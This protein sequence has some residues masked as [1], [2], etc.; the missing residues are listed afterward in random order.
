MPDSAILNARRV[1]L[2]GFFRLHPDD[3]ARVMETFPVTEVVSLLEGAVPASGAAIFGRLSP[4]VAAEVL[5]RASDDLAG[6]FIGALSPDRAA[7]LLSRVEEKERSR[8]LARLNHAAA[9]E[10][11]T[12]MTY[13]EETAGRLM[14]PH[15]V[16]FRR[17]TIVRQVLS[18]LRTLRE[19]RVHE[20]FLVDEEGL[21]TGVVSLQDLALAAPGEQMQTL[22]HGIPETVPATG[23][24]DEVV[25]KL[26]SGLTSLPV[27]DFEGRLLGV[28][29]HNAIIAAAQQEASADIQAMVGASREERALSS[30]PFA[31]RR[32][33]PWLN[34]NLVTAFLAASVVGVFED[35]IAKFTAL[36]VLLPVVAGQSGNTGAQALAVTMRGLALREIRLRHWLQVTFK[37]LRVAA[38]NGIAIAL[39]TSAGVFL[40]SGS[41]GLTMVIG[42]AMIISM[43]MAGIAGAG[44][45]MLLTAL[46]QDPAQSSSIV[47]TTV[48]DIV[49]FFSFLG[50]ATLFASLL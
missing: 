26:Q 50:L 36:A 28:I 23:P 7:A 20:V 4:Q 37:E 19:R 34:I 14:D 35:T 33:L 47:L 25:E 30:V 12:L 22:S 39:V 46:G 44:I 32:R 29:R 41:M 18:R 42:L 43:V 27:V 40:W 9:K 8:Y 48:T 49:G 1:A 17:R 15:V 38:V 2:Q 16:A 6:H 31:V 11:E 5:T 10:I 21:L 45:P 24:R 3:A 13:P